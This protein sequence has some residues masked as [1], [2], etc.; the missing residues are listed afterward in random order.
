MKALLKSK[1]QN[2]D[3]TCWVDKVVRVFYD[4]DAQEKKVVIL[5]ADGQQS[6]EP[7]EPPYDNLTEVVRE[8]EK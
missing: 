2:E 8:H 7:F 1:C 3:G 5:W 4:K 6:V